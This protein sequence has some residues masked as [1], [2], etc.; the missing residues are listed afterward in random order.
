V[1]A[2]NAFR[3]DVLNAYPSIA[4][5]LADEQLAGRLRIAPRMVSTSSELRTAEMTERIERAFGVRAFDLYGTTEGLWGVECDHHDG[6]HLFEDWCIVE[7]VDGDGRPVADGAQ[8]ERLLVTNL[9]NRTLPMI[10]FAISDVVTLDG[11]PCACGRTLPRL[12]GVQGRLDDVLRL[13]GASGR[14][15]P[16]H[17]TQFS[18]VAGDPAVREFQVRQRGPR[19]LLRLALR[20]DA[21]VETPDR[22]VRAVTERLSTLRVE[23]PA[24]AAEVTESI[25]RT[26]AGKLAMVVP[27]RAAAVPHESLRGD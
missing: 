21:A 10:R 14:T 3:P 27:D 23:R 19:I 22:I 26:P 20:D 6:I 15:V 4:A 1:E 12:R 9:F 16:V 18:L 13:P 17:P 5:L 2:L 8:G 24:V 11:S 7:N 25:E